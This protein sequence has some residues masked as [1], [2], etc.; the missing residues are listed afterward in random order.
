MKISDAMI[1]LTVLSI[2]VLSS[3]HA[4]AATKSKMEKC[5]GIAKAGMN[6]CQTATAKCASSS[7]KDGQRDAFIFLPKGICSRIVGGN[8][9]DK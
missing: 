4:L 8:L 9:T 1:Q 2:L 7:T 5:Y 6:D 3:T